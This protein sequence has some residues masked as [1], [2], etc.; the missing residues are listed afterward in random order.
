MD[1]TEL[2]QN[3]DFLDIALE[4]MDE[5]CLEYGFVEDVYENLCENF[6]RKS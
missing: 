5:D 4:E 3:I 6:E 1:S 2:Q